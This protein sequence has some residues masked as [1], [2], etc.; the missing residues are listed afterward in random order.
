VKETAELEYGEDV[1]GFDG[2][3]LLLAGP[4]P[5]GP[6]PPDVVLAEEGAS[7]IVADVVVFG[8]VEWW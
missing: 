3:L 1:D 2:E 5:P 8:P 4:F 6:L 7:T